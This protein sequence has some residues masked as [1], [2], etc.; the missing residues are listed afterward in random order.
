MP[1][2]S[3]IRNC[4]LVAELL[5]M[6]QLV[7]HHGVAEVQVGRGGVEAEL[8]AQRRAARELA[9]ELLLDDQLVAAALDEREGFSDCR[10]AFCRAGDLVLDC[11]RHLN[12]NGF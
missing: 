11:R 5:E 4:T 2:K 1:V 12:I 9:R 8:D 3:P 10:L 6:A 7:D